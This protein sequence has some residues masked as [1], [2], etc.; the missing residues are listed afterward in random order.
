VAT[1]VEPGRSWVPI[2][3]GSIEFF[4][5]L[6]LPAALWSWDGA[7]SDGNEYQEYFLGV[8]AA[9]RPV[10][11]ADNLT[12]FMCRLSRSSEILGVLE[13]SE[14]VQD[15]IGFAYLLNYLLT[16]LLTPWCRVLLEKLTCLQLVKKFPAFYRT[17]RFITAFTTARQLSLNW[18]TESNP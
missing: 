11:G 9:G 13:C 16:Y 14:S 18:A 6:I 15:S 4:T 8:K 1:L 3:V 7:A 5:N 10:C 2:P 12:T 17:R